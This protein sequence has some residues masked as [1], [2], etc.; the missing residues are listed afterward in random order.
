MAAQ[1]SKAKL[2]MCLLLAAVCMLGP[3]AQAQEASRQTMS[4]DGWPT[5][6]LEAMARE[7]PTYEALPVSVPV[8]NITGQLKGKALGELEEVPLG[9]YLTSD[10]EAI[11][12]IECWIFTSP[13]DRAASVRNIA[14]ININAS[15]KING[16]ITERH[17]F[18]ID[19]GM[20]GRSPYLALEILYF[21]GGD[22]QNL[23]GFVKVRLAGRD[24]VQFGCSHNQIGFRETFA[25]IFAHFINSAT[26]DASGSEPFLR[27]VYRQSIN[28]LPIGIVD[29][30]Y[31][32]DA[33][34]DLAI[35]SADSTLMPSN[36]SDIDSTDNYEIGYWKPDGALINQIF[37][38]AENAEQV[39]RLNFQSA[40]ENL[41][42]LTGTYQGEELEL[43]I[44]SS[45]APVSD[46]EIM[47]EAQRMITDPDRASMSV[48]T[49]QATIDPVQFIETRISLDPE[50]RSDLMGTASFGPVNLDV[51]LDEFGQLRTGTTVFESTTI[52]MERIF[53]EGKS[54]TIDR[55]N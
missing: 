28:G 3:A 37:I 16:A 34:G 11:T 9:W 7:R 5:W 52:L 27:Q 33:D 17:I 2:A 39:T 29:T 41:Y 26:F 55:D 4:M 30:T 12:P 42:R 43:E 8:R 13:V 23:A 49:W 18:S 35:S 47:L 46:I 50:R 53:K 25:D 19:S 51:Q 14:Q 20:I 40:G 10:I 15:A 38:S 48:N 54:P 6:L 31:A 45:H 36:G 22:G 32:I 21:M 44:N 24:G 1:A